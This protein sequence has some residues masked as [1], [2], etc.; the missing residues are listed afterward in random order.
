L[1][2]KEFLYTEVI[3]GMNLTGNLQRQR[4]DPGS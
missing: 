1:T 4:P 2:L 3:E